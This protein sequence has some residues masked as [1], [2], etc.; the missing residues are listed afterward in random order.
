[1]T[2]FVDVEVYVVL[3]APPEKQQINKGKVKS[4]REGD[5]SGKAGAPRYC[6]VEFTDETKKMIKGT[7][8]D[9]RARLGR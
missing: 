5:S 3:G 8:A 6:V 4:F 1:M 2:E 7:E 9:V